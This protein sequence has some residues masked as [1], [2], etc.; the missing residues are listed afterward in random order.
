MGMKDCPLEQKIVT[1]CY[2]VDLVNISFV[3]FAAVSKDIARVSD[4][5]GAAPYFVTHYFHKMLD[6]FF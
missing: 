3:N 2:G 1:V 4:L 5:T 6:N